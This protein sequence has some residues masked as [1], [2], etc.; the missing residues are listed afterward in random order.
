V[1]PTQGSGRFVVLTLEALKRAGPE[2]P[3]RITAEA[4]E[5]RIPLVVHGQPGRRTRAGRSLDAR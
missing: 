5:G 3:I 1:T 2:S 4:N